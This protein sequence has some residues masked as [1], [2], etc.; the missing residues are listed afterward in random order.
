MVDFSNLVQELHE[1]PNAVRKYVFVNIKSKPG[2][3][4]KPATSVNKSYRDAHFKGI[5]KRTAG[6]RK[7]IKFD[8]DTIDESRDFEIRLMIKHCITGWSNPPLDVSGNPV[9][10]SHQNCYQFFKV[11]PDEM[12]DDFRSWVQES[13]N[14]IG[15][16][17]SDFGSDEIKIDG[18]DIE[19]DSDEELGNST[20]SSQSGNSD[21]SGMDSA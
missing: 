16:D 19:E 3:L 17:D 7:K 2:I 9:P 12:V 20:L 11:L 1:D 5:G 15:D 6:G 10:Y 21:T 13:S 14:F 18:D 8:G 4:S